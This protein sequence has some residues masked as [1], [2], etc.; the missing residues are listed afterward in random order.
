MR[1]ITSVECLEW[2]ELHEIDAVCERGFPKVVG[3]YEVFFAA[4]TEA[5]TQQSLA[6]E[7]IEWVGAFDTALFWISEW[8]LLQEG[9]NGSGP[10]F[11]ARSR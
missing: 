3:D 6:R 8:P 5:R 9:G 7:M 11:T 1:C 10:G 2:L 4:P